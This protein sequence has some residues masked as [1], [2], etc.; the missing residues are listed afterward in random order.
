MQDMFRLSK[1]LNHHSHFSVSLNSLNSA[2]LKSL[3]FFSEGHVIPIPRYR[4]SD[5]IIFSLLR[6]IVK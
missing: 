1:T 4:P 3:M 2:Y 5:F 6:G